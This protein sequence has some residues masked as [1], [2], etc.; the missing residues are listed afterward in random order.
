MFFNILILKPSE[1]CFRINFTL[2]NKLAIEFSTHIGLW[3][4]VISWFYLLEVA[5]IGRI[6]CY[7][8]IN[9]NF[10][11]PKIRSQSTSHFT[12]IL[13]LVVL[14]DNLPIHRK[15]RGLYLSNCQTNL[16]IALYA[17]SLLFCKFINTTAYHL[18]RYKPSSPISCHAPHLYSWTLTPR[19]G[20]IQAALS[21]KIA[22]GYVINNTLM[23]AI[24]T[25][26]MIIFV[27]ESTTMRVKAKLL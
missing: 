14:L 1:W 2:I 25:F 20:I 26:Y 24:N 19:K 11:I 9:K 18:G 16:V 15:R 27:V 7:N 17:L 3:Q 13:A 6:S 4:I 12:L 8:R 22:I 10:F 5:I 23:I 21:Y